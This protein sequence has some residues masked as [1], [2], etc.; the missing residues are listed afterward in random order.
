[1]ANYQGNGTQL[2]WLLIPHQQAVDIWPAAGQ[3]K[4]QCIEPATT[5]DASPLFPGLE[6][7]LQEICSV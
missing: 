1:M 6:I 5:L 7:K 3:G 2:G 4:T